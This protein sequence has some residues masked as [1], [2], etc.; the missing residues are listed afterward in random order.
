MNISKGQL[1]ENAERNSAVFVIENYSQ[2]ENDHNK[3]EHGNLPLPII[4]VRK[5]NINL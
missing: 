3:E 5:T 1:V 4:P 2:S